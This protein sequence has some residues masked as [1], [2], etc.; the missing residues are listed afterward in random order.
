VV[1]RGKSQQVKQVVEAL[2]A[3]GREDLL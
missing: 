2:K 1:P 3:K